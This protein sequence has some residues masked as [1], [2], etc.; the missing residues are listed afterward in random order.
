MKAGR[1]SAWYLPLAASVVLA[2]P[3]S[4]LDRRARVN[5]WQVVDVAED[6]GGTLVSLE[7]AAAGLRLEYKAIFWRGNHGILHD[8]LIDSCGSGA[9]RSSDPAEVTAA[10]LRARFAGLLAACDVAP[11]QGAAALE[12]LEAAFAVAA[13]WIGEAARAL[14][15]ENAEIA[16]Y[17][18]DA[19]A[20]PG[21]ADPPRPPTRPDA[22]SSLISGG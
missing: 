22:P 5:G 15:A 21:A 2:T 9:F 20:D 4:G 8:V 11:E 10:D 19:D 6:D 7:R 18:R 14:D 3:A 13:G 1:G 16:D 12:G 17:G